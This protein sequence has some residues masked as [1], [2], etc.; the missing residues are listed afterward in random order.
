MFPKFQK[1]F[2]STSSARRTTT[3]TPTRTTAEQKFQSTSSA[4]RTTLYGCIR[5]AIIQFQSTSSA[6][7]T[8]T[9]HL[10]LN[11]SCSISIHVL[12]KEDDPAQGAHK[13][14]QRPFQSTSSARRTTYIRN[15]IIRLFNDFNPRPPQGGRQIDSILLYSLHTISIHVLRKEDDAGRAVA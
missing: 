8:T 13:P 4:R 1:R 6:R 9:S 11:T 7:R 14:P 3:G 12:R 2:Q 10:R 15:N 5:A